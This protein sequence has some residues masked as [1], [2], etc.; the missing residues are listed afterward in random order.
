MWYYQG[1][2][3]EVKQ[4]FRHKL[5]DPTRGVSIFGTVPPPMKVEMEKVEQ[6]AK[7]M[8]ESLK[9]LRPDGVIVYDIQDEKS[10][11]GEERPFP[12]SQT[13]EPRLFGR[14]LVQ[15]SS[16][17]KHQLEPIVFK[18]HSA[19]ESVRDKKTIEKIF[20]WLT[21]TWDNYHIRNL[22]LVGGSSILNQDEGDRKNKPIMTVQQIS[23]LIVDEH[24]RDFVLGGITIA[25][26][27]RDIGNEHLRIMN[28]ID[29]GI[30]FFTSQVIYNADNA[31]WMLRDYDELCKER[32]IQPV[33]LFFTFAPFGS[34]STVRFLRWLGVEMP[35]GTMK[36]AL[37]RP[38]LK[39]RVDESIEICWENFTRILAACN[40]LKISVPIGVSVECVSK[41]KMESEG[42]L[43]LFTMLKEE[44]DNF[45]ADPAKTALRKSS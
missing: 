4:D 15:F 25:E 16:S 26:R 20:D 42:A 23:Q 1:E 3:A 34:D 32:G 29:S 38:T 35:D 45:Y 24:E 40:R 33:R 6:F 7:E 37:S 9:E 13:H 8:A 41:S 28:K 5:R 30:E 2:D 22:V 10:R 18:A 17:F 11:S 14:M 12:F 31:I 27:H 21:E 19:C 39:Q 36:R 44:L 43:Q